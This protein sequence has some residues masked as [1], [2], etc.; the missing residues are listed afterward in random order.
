M[1]GPRYEDLM[2]IGTETLSLRQAHFAFVTNN[3]RWHL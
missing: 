1:S 2:N 3:I